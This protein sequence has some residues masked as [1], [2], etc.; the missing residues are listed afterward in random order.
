METVLRQHDHREGWWHPT[1][2]PGTWLARLTQERDELLLALHSI[3]HAQTDEG[4]RYAV[5]S[6]MQEC[7]D[8]ANFAM[9]CFDKLVQQ[10]R[11]E[12]REGTEVRYLDDCTAEKARTR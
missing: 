7:C 2:S 12:E 3:G 5:L 4:E 9:M 11:P 6:A 10:F 1:Y 8:V